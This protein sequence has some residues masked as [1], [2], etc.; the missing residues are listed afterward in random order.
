MEL[1]KERVPSLLET[2]FG[3]HRCSTARRAKRRDS[4][5]L[6]RASLVINGKPQTHPYPWFLAWARKS[7]I[8]GVYMVPSYRKTLWK[9]WGGETPQFSQGGFAVGWGPW[10]DP[11]AGPPDGNISNCTPQENRSSPRA[12]ETKINPPTP[13]TKRPE[14]AGGLF[15][16]LLDVRIVAFRKPETSNI[17]QRQSRTGG[18]H[19]GSKG[20]Y[21]DP[22]DLWSWRTQGLVRRRPRARESSRRPPEGPHAVNIWWSNK[23]Y[24]RKG[25]RLDLGC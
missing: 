16:R 10:L 14:L 18:T 7:S 11:R 6:N 21:T 2:W 3:Y 23:E 17:A 19:H 15:S 24:S 22:T 1:S 8:W 25:N 13:L 9:R 12:A 5:V 20:S 4:K